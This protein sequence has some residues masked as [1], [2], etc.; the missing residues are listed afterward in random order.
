MSDATRAPTPVSRAAPPAAPSETGSAGFAERR[1][2]LRGQR[3]S[4]T[5]P[6][7][8]AG[9]SRVGLAPSALHLELP[10][11]AAVVRV[12]LARCYCFA[13]QAARTS[14]ARVVA[15]LHRL[16]EPERRGA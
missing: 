7:A 13:Q 16:Y 3:R 10:A 15:A 6:A 4:R 11:L 1:T 9:N 2:P 12:Y 8:R 14:S 5:Y